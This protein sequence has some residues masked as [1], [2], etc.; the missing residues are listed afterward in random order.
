MLERDLDEVLAAFKIDKSDVTGNKRYRKWASP[1]NTRTIAYEDI[2][3]IDNLHMGPHYE[4]HS[5]KLG[6]RLVVLKVFH[7]PQA[8]EHS[9]SAL[10]FSHQFLNPNIL[11]AV[12][13]SSPNSSVPFIVFDGSCQA[14]TESRIASAL[15]DSLSR[16]VRLGL[17]IVG[18]L[19]A[20][21]DYLFMN[22]MPPSF[23][24]EQA[25]EI[26]ITD[27]DSIKIGF[28]AVDLEPGLDDDIGDGADKEDKR[29]RMFNNLC[30]KTFRQASQLLHQD[31]G[32]N[33][34][35]SESAILEILDDHIPSRSISGRSDSTSTQSAE[36]PS[37]LVKP[38]RELVWRVPAD[39]STTV[40]AIARHYRR[41]LQAARIQDAQHPSLRQLRARTGKQSRIRHRCLGYKKEE[42]NL[43]TTIDDSAV[44]SRVTPSLH[45]LC[46]VC[47]EIVDDR[48]EFDCVCGLEDDGFSA[49]AKCSICHIW[50]HLACIDLQGE[51]NTAFVCDWCQLRLPQAD[52]GSAAWERSQNRSSFTLEQFSNSALFG[53]EQRSPLPFIP[54]LYSPPSPPLPQDENSS[55]SAKRRRHT[56]SPLSSPFIPPRASPPPPPPLEIPQAR[57]GWRRVTKRSNKRP[58][59]PPPQFVPGS[60]DEGPWPQV[61]S[62]ATWQ[63][64]PEFQPTPPS[65]VPT[66]LVPDHGSP[67]LFGPR[68]PRAQSWATWQPDPQFQPTP[69]SVEPAL[70]PEVEGSPGLFGPRSPRH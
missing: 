18:G 15:T 65:P 47:G 31:E 21:L 59:S 66:L 37:S 20:G 14:N 26:Y 7:G 23:F 68:T 11:R 8:D 17:T 4:V 35:E 53:Q 64:N 3:P 5:A 55:T 13:T 70:L 61:P 44:I 42:I 60:W 49:T 36:E 30:D 48:G 33:R 62:W 52:G 32:T 45:E 40:S 22:D 10:T 29:W 19:S 1:V 12:A 63:P 67:G 39:G 16:S 2:D 51:R 38:R 43:T 24:M 28:G 6:G 57:P 54:P 58:I 50:S 56:P 27:D 25:L 41:Y 46:S 34:E 69:P 9:R